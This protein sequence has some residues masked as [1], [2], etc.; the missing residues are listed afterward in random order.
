MYDLIYRLEIRHCYMSLFSLTL[1]TGTQG[2]R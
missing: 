2:Q 1:A